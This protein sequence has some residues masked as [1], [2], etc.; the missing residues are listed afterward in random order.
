MKITRI[1][2]NLLVL[3]SLLV[4][5]GCCYDGHDNEPP[6]V[7]RG[8]RSITGDEEVLLVWYQNTEPD[9]AGYRVYRSLEP[10]G[11]YYEVGETNLDY[12]LDYGLTNGVTYYYAVTAFD[13][14]G[15]ESEFSYEIVYDTPRPEGYDEQ[16]FD[17]TLY[18]DF[19]GWKFSAY[20]IVAYDNPT[21]DF[22]YGYDSFERTYY[23]YVGNPDGLIQDFGYTSSMDE[24]TYAPQHGW[25]MTGR[26]EAIPGH[27][28][29]MHTWDNHYA[30]FRVTALGT[31][32][33]I[34]DWA[35]QIDIGNP[36]LMIVR[37]LN[38]QGG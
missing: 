15:N 11:L 24:I 30:K 3:P 16:I 23:F 34:F 19:A 10:L 1:L 5:A 27:T 4:L 33:V 25:S 37:S 22:Y 18:P 2:P 31:I 32:S 35:Y 29:I 36:E 8:V 20:N 21:C 7:P 26:V 14:K 38:N 28:Y 6:A 13:Y 9:L 12:F 17:Y